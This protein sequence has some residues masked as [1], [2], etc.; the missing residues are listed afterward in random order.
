[1][2]SIVFAFVLLVCFT[3]CKKGLPLNCY[4][5]FY[6]QKQKNSICLQDCPG[7][8]GCDGKNYCNECGMHSKGIK[9]KK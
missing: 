9:R 5:W 7:V 6:Y 1:M 8:I 4:D 3:S 2:K